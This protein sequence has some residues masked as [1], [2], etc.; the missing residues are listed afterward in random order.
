MK[1]ENQTSLDLD[2]R[3]IT[4]GDNNPP[5]D[6]P[7][8]LPSAEELKI[9]I[10]NDVEASVGHAVLELDTYSRVPETIENDEIYQRVTT[11]TTRIKDVIDTADNNRKN[12]K[13]PY[14][15]AGK[16]IDDEFALV[17]TV[18]DGTVRKLKKELE[19]ATSALKKK[20][21]E[22]DTK[23]YNEEQQAAEAE[24]ALLAEAAAKDGI[25]MEATVSNVAIASSVKSAHGGQ[26]V[27]SLVTEWEIEDESLL[28]R[29]VLSVDR[30][31]VE[32]LIAD[33]ATEIPGI[34]ITKKVKTHVKKK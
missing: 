14:L 23:K 6:L 26:S 13:A 21:S 33:G 29:S 10:K 8:Q 32:K 5:E 9:I 16:L 20:L 17:L 3:V 25:E 18:P 19:D 2:G 34:K 4:K 22:Y 24:R 28:P 7:P 15:K 12:H 11:L 31:K 27:R 1:N 30:A